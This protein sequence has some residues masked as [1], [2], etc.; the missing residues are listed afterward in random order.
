VLKNEVGKGATF[1][2][3]AGQEIIVQGIDPTGKYV[4]VKKTSGEIRL[5]PAN[6]M[7]TIGQVGN[8]DMLNVKSR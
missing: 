6:A 4:Q 8:E 5:I 7:A 3:S 2:R 1:A